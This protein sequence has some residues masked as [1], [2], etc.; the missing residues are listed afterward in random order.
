VVL[1]TDLGATVTPPDSTSDAAAAAAAWHQL[2][3]LPAHSAD[4]V[5]GPAAQVS[6]LAPDG[7]TLVSWRLSGTESWVRQQVMKVPVPLGSS[8]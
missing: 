1:G 5:L 7:A 4:L 3:V 8:G 2:P 6:A